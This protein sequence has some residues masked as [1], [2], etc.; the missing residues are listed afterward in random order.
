MY[1]Y[2]G[3]LASGATGVGESYIRDDQD[4]IVTVEAD[5][6]WTYAYSPGEILYESEVTDDQRMI[7][8]ERRYVQEIVRPR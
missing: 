5:F 3:D 8:D 1:I 7:L 6:G 2:D 4:R